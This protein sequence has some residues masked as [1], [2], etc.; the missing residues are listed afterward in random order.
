MSNTIH[1]MRLLDGIVGE[2][3]LVNDDCFI[4]LGTDI[5]NQFQ[6]AARLIKNR[7]GFE[8]LRDVFYLQMGGFDTHSDNGPALTALLSQIDNAIGCFK[9]EMDN[10]LIW[11]NVTVSYS[12]LSS[13]LFCAF[14]TDTTPSPTPPK[15]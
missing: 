3:T 8:A 1:R 15:S 6:Q 13:F 11:N 7:D 2:T 5:A 4:G 12:C 9:T 14:F 10:Q